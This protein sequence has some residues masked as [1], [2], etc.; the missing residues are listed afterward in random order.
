MTEH[1]SQEVNDFI[2][3]DP[4]LV[5]SKQEVSLLADRRKSGD[6]SSF[7]GNLTLGGLSSWC[8]G[9]AQERR[10]R[11]IG[12]VLK[13]ENCP[14]FPHGFTHFRQRTLQPF[15]TSLV[16]RLEI[17]TLRFLVCQS[18]FS[19]PSPNRVLRHDHLE[20]L[21]NNLMYPSHGPQVCLISEV[22]RRLKNQIPKPLAVHLPQLS[23]ASAPNLPTQANFSLS[24]IA[25]EPPKQGSAVS[26]VC[27]RNVAD[28]E[29]STQHSLHCPC[30]HFV[31][32][33]SSVNH[34][35]RICRPIL[36]ESTLMLQIYCDEPYI[37]V[38]L[39]EPEQ[40]RRAHQY[41]CVRSV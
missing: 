41:C 5:Q 18:R 28:R 29:A 40:G 21:L 4:L 15:L 32:R 9:L 19:K 6:P 39:P 38:F 25:F 16:V 13:I 1:L 7:S 33:I 36:F 31:R 8:P 22:C 3:S 30:P 10:Q 23:W 35:G 26:T 12:L 27:F 17:L 2:R 11:N 14:V 34:G 20:F 24:L 37:L